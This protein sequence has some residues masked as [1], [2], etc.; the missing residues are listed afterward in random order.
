MDKVKERLTNIFSEL[1]EEYNYIINSLPDNG[2][3]EFS[4]CYID[5]LV[6]IINNSKNKIEELNYKY[7]CEL[8]DNDINEEYQKKMKEYETKDKILKQFMPYMLMYQMYLTGAL[9]TSS[10]EV[11][12][13]SESTPDVKIET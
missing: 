4:F 11:V 3:N 2:I 12:D 10:D 9:G 13:V 1:S 8:N 5:E 6:S 7:T